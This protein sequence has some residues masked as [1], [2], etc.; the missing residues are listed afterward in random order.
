MDLI[1]IKEYIKKN[2][3]ITYD[4]VTQKNTTKKTGYSVSLYDTEKQ[5]KD[6]NKMLEE[7]KEYVKIAKEYNKESINNNFYI[8]VWY[9]KD[10]Y[11]L[12]LSTIISDRRK[13]V[14][15]AEKNQQL[16]IYDIKNNKD[17]ILNY[18]V[19]YY[20]LYKIIRVK[21]QNI[22]DYKFINNYNTLEEIKTYLNTTLDV[23]KKI[24]SNTQKHRNNNMEYTI[25]KGYIN[26][27]D[28][29]YT[30]E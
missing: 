27:K 3:G 24:S 22:I 30:E 19:K 25:D 11:F 26:I 7:F 20:S 5:F 6:I 16:A 29:V 13:A 14:K 9:Y 2:G 23:V 17:I 4:V 10:T 12:D 21:K 18:N 28:L 1:Y 15:F 8:G